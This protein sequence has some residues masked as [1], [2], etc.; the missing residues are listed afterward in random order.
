MTPHPPDWLKYEKTVFE[1]LQF[2]YAEAEVVHDVSLPG[3]LSGVPRQIDVLVTERFGVKTYVTAFEAKYYA[4]KIDVKGVEEAIGLF[5]D[6]GVDRGVM[7][8]TMGYSDAAL[9]RANADDVDIDLDIL[10]LVEL[11]TFQTDGCAIPYKGPHGVVIPAPLGWI[12]DGTRTAWGLARLYRRGVTFEQ[13]H[14]QSEFMYV[15]FWN[16]ESEQISS[17]NDLIYS[18]NQGMLR[19]FPNAEITVESLDLGQK[20]KGAIRTAANIY[21]ALEVTAFAEFEKF[22]LFVVLLTPKVVFNRNR[23]K[24]EY[25]VRKALPLSVKHSPGDK[26]ADCLTPM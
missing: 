16:K 25:V 14:N 18:Q 9:R 2:D 22:I 5:L 3:R 6:V 17:L 15:Q 8:T 19:D 11:E 13:A 24:L 21:P 10:D 1:Y 7:I 12:I 26:A 23:R 4:R 20:S